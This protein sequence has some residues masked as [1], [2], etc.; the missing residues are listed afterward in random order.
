MC[1]VCSV[2]VLCRNGKGLR[3]GNGLRAG[4]GLREGKGVVGRGRGCG[5]REGAA[6]KGGGA[7]RTSG[8]GRSGA[9]ENTN[10]KNTALKIE[11]KHPCEYWHEREHKHQ[12]CKQLAEN[13]G[14]IDHSSNLVSAN[15]TLPYITQTALRNGRTRAIRAIAQ[16]PPS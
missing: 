11:L 5:N 15:A 6:G 3:E 8:I 10:F 1:C 12:R 14:K 4:T 13:S 9:L 2:Y 16:P 7:G